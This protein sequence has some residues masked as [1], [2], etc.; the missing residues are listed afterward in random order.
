MSDMNIKEL[1][2]DFYWIGAQDPALRIFDIIMRTEFGTTYNSYFLKG[3]EKTVLFETVKEPFYEDYLAKLSALADPDRI[4]YLV[5]SHTEPDHAGSIAKLLQLNPDI[6]IVATTCAV[7]YLKQITNRPFKSI[8]VKD[9]DTLSIGGKTLRFLSLPNL[10]WPDTMYTYI[11]ED[12]V[13]VTCDSF[14]AHYCHDGVLR[15]TVAPEAEPDYLRAAKYY[16]D[17]IIGPFKR[18]F[19]TNAL[20]RVKML[21]V[22]MICPGHGPVL[23]SRIDQI[24]DLYEAWCGP[25]QTAH[26]KTVV[27]P[28]VSAYGYT[29]QLAEAIGRGVADS[30]EIDVRLYDMTEHTAEEVLAVLP[31][32]DGILLGTPTILG[33]ALKP[34]YDL[35]GAM[36][37]VL[38]R[39]K[40]AAAFGSYGWSGEGVPHIMERLRQLKCKVPEE[41]FRVR[42]RPAEEDLAAAYQYGRNFGAGI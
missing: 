22:D 38:Y 6:M 20:A 41:G 12:R 2:K 33:D 3:T 19:M 10:H 26:K 34:I 18:P 4:D 21:A 35:T 1:K 23:D 15:S 7:G 28:Y 29:R 5:V 36:V 42:F 37:P 31:G 32:A 13:L 40:P 11:E 25:E 24:L 17:N 39:G 14:G 16:F 27:I 8:A 30:G 9:G